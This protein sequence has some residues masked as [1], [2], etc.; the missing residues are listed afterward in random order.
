MTQRCFID[1]VYGKTCLSALLMHG[2][3]CIIDFKNHMT[4]ASIFSATF[5]FLLGVIPTRS[6]LK[7]TTLEDATIAVLVIV[8]IS[9]ATTLFIPGGM[10]SPAQ[11]ALG[12]FGS[13]LCI[14]SFV[15]FAT[16]ILNKTATEQF[17]YAE[18]LTMDVITT[19]G[20]TVITSILAYLL[21]IAQP[22]QALALLLAL[23]TFS[24][25]AF[26]LM[27]KGISTI[28]G[29]TKWKAFSISIVA[30]LPGVLLYLLLFLT[31]GYYGFIAM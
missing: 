18:V 21:T 6:D 10:G 22:L 31:L 4:L 8:C 9:Q 2:T 1:V 3:I 7:N 26:I 11:L 19:G 28:A 24:I 25:Y 12:A 27:L 23:I 14:A 29:I 5:D 16:H 30:M 20:M 15:Y 13:I 17:T